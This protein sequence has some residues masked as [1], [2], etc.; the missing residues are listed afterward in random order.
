MTGRTGRGG[1]RRAAV[2]AAIA[3]GTVL[4]TP[5]AVAAA[6]GGLPPKQ[7]RTADLAVDSAECV[8]GEQRPYVR[9]VPRVT[10]RLYGPGGGQPGESSQVRGEFEAWWQGEDGA[11]KRVT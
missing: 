10:A 2:A 6:D 5:G 4:A 11:E 8:T 9:T 3:A 1:A 7:P